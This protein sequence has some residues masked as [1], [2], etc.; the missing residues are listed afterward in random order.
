MHA[1]THIPHRLMVNVLTQL[2]DV[3]M[4]AIS[5]SSHT[6]LMQFY[7]GKKYTRGG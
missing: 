7:N 5:F 2:K 4:I 3:K 1:R 6:K